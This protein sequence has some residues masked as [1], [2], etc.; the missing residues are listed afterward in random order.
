MNGLE[1]KEMLLDRGALVTNTV[2]KKT[3][4]LIVGENPGSKYQKAID[5]EIEIID[6]Q[7]LVKLLAKSH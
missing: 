6:A 7:K 5:L 3:K 2:S 4:A 1:L